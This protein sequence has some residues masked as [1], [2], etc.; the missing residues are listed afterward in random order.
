ML[1]NHG[2]KSDLRRVSSERSDRDMDGRSTSR[3]CVQ[4]QGCGQR[5]ESTAMMRRHRNNG[6]LS[7]ANAAKCRAAEAMPA[8]QQ[9][10]GPIRYSTGT[11]GRGYNQS[12]HCAAA[13]MMTELDSDDDAAQQFVPPSMQVHTAVH[14]CK[15]FVT[16][17]VPAIVPVS[18]VKQ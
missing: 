16:S 9:S 11:S 6:R 12:S 17:S 7:G 5:F 1:G 14:V 10:E 2:S 13:L 3:D 18:V 4:C 15:A 8:P